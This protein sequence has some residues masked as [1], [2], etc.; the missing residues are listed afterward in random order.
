[1]ASINR[2]LVTEHEALEPI[3]NGASKCY[4]AWHKVYLE[5]ADWSDTTRSLLAQATDSADPNIRSSR[6]FIMI[7]T[8]TE[9]HNAMGKADA[10]AQ[11]AEAQLAKRFR[12]S[13]E[14]VLQ[15]LNDS[16]AIA[17]RVVVQDWDQQRER[18]QSMQES[19]A[20][21]Q[22]SFDQTVASFDHSLFALP[23]REYLDSVHKEPPSGWSVDPLVVEAVCDRAIERAAQEYP[24]REHV[25][26]VEAA[27]KAG[28]VALLQILEAEPFT[29]P[30]PQPSALGVDRAISVIAS[31][32]VSSEAQAEL[33]GVINTFGI[34]FGR[35]VE[36]LE[37]T[38][39]SSPIN[40]L[41]GIRAALCA[42]HVKNFEIAMSDGSLENYAPGLKD[43]LALFAWV[44][45]LIGR[46]T[47]LDFAM[48]K[49]WLE[50][51]PPQSAS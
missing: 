16:G 49:D 28:G 13:D 33:V 4:F 47:V 2:T 51:R 40:L 44:H 22:A 35:W 17:D 6:L 43:D 3:P 25:A 26:W 19:L 21:W 12:V 20:S 46:T 1:M 27:S 29:Q 15:A 36:T 10:S 32:W 48:R 38:R 50:Q 18:L 11:K 30:V 7:A 5:F 39:G 37:Q 23:F 45:F 14:E 42:E 41:N 8:S 34:T 31:T 24:E 9:I